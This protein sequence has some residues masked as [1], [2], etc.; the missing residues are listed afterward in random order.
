MIEKCLEKEFL[1][2]QGGTLAKVFLGQLELGFTMR[3]ALFIE[4]SGNWQSRAHWFGVP[5]E[6]DCPAFLAKS[7]REILNLRALN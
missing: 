7:T 3:K 6:A 2:L 1:N 5:K 4:F